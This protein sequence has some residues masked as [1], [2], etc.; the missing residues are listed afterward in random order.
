VLGTIGTA[1]YRGNMA[2]AAL[3]RVPEE[4]RVVARDT[5]G[6]ATAAATHLPPDVGAALLHAARGAFATAMQATLVICAVVAAL[7]GVMVLVARRDVRRAP[8][9]GGVA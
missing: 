4:A 5:L 9:E 7:T 3:G 2:G 6:G 8:A 1:I